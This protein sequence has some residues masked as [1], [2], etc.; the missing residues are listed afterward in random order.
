MLYG[1]L[2]TEAATDAATKALLD[3]AGL[4]DSLGIIARVIGQKLAIIP[5]SGYLLAVAATLLPIGRWPGMI[6]LR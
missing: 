6:G 4:W 5:V 3:N 2:R 1:K